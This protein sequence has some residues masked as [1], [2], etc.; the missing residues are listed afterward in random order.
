VPNL[1][2]LF[3]LPD[4]VVS[5]FA[6]TRPLVRVNPGLLGHIGCVLFCPNEVVVPINRNKKVP[7][8]TICQW[9]VTDLIVHNNIEEY[10]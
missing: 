9:L 6:N 10:F 1:P 4:V 5:A 7:N 8:T 2:N 3:A